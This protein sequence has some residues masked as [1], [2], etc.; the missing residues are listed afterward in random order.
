MKLSIWR[1]DV[2]VSDARVLLQ[3]SGDSKHTIWSSLEKHLVPG[4][5]LKAKLAF[6]DIWESLHGHS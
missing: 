2:D 3:A 1:D 5:E 4:R 6:D